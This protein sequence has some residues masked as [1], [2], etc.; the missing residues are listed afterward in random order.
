MLF[1]ISLALVI[2]SAHGQSRASKANEGDVAVEL[3]GSIAEQ[4][5][6]STYAVAWLDSM[7]QQ[8]RYRCA[9][10]L[11]ELRHFAASFRR[12]TRFLIDIPRATA[13]YHQHFGNA[14]LP[15]PTSVLAY[16]L[17]NYRGKSHQK[18]AAAPMLIYGQENHSEYSLEK[19]GFGI[20]TRQR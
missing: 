7:T 9:D 14:G 17:V 13:E 4:S 15:R 12:E 16:L 6:C 5:D 20:W 10:T 2:V 18:N 11:F 1:A 19:N 8:V 3:F